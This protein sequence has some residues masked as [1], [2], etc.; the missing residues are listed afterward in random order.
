MY[1][2]KDGAKLPEKFKI[3]V[4]P[5]Q[6]EA[7]QKQVFS[8]GAT[9]RTMDT[10][11]RYKESPYLFLDYDAILTHG[12]GETDSYFANRPHPE[13]KFADYFNT[14]AQKDTATDAVLK[15]LHKHADKIS[16]DVYS[17]GSCSRHLE[18]KAH[19]R[20]DGV[21]TNFDVTLR[22]DEIEKAQVFISNI[23]A[24]L[25]LTPIGLRLHELAREN[26][27]LK[28]DLETARKFDRA[29]YKVRLRELRKKVHELEAAKT[30]HPVKWCVKITEDNKSILADY[31]KQNSHKYK[32][33]NET[34]QVNDSAIGFYFLSES[35]ERDFAC[36]WV[37]AEYSLIK[38]KQ[39]K[40]I[41]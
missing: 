16:T 23:S 28:A 40:R 10:N 19:I 18:I 34:W 36:D 9:W 14:A 1:K 27:I 21:G 7:V 22:P 6:S 39:L 29:Y 4:T 11:V 31:L 30:D 41:L 26:T 37:P 17:D 33:I 15:F 13:I 12:I 32:G 35:R 38:T 24:V 20:K 5:A 25:G 3:K 2:I 8:Q